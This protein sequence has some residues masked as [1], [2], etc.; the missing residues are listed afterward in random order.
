MMDWLFFLLFLKAGLLSQGPV[1]SS[2]QL[3]FP[4]TQPTCQVLVISQKPPVT[5]ARCP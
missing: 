5:V 3:V 2:P 4:A 1:M